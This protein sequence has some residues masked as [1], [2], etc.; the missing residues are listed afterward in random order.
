MPHSDNL[1]PVTDLVLVVG[2]TGG[3]GQLTVSE[4]LTQNIKVRVLVRNAAKAQEMFADQVEIIVGDTR[5]ADT[6]PAAMPGVTHIISCTGSTAFPT[7]RWQFRQT[8]SK[9]EWCKRYANPNYCR[10]QAEN[11]PEKV[12]AI[13]GQNLVNAAPKDLKRFLLVSACGVERKDKLPFSLLNSFGV[14]DAKLVGE[15][16]LR[17]SGLPYTI[18]RPGRLI[19]GPYTS[20]DL[21]TLLKAKTES[22]LGI[23]LGRGDIL[24]G[25]T[26]RIDLAAACVA[27]LHNPQMVGKVFEIMSAGPRPSPIDWDGLLVQLA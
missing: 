3:V 5:Q 17:N 27:C 6:I 14:L 15:T 25:E 10:A 7:S 18:V 9:W 19:D 20:Y 2:A 21:N 11:S 12:D 23:V 8:S 13:G 4:L 1:N 26:S 22:Q 16:V 24:S